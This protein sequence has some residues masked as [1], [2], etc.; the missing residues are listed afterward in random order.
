MVKSIITYLFLVGIPL[1]ALLWILDYGEQRI[2]APPAIAGS[3]S[4]DEPLTGCLDVQPTE[5]TF[6]QSGRFIQVALGEA[7]GEARLDGEELRASVS[8]PNG[9]CS[10][11]EIVGTF[12]VANE[13][14]LGHATGIGCN[15]CQT[16]ALVAQ[17]GGK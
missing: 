14:F 16:V 17:H 9:P 6:K 5:L 3:W 15:A 13:R 2:A 11:V 7:S 8:E 12:D 4:I 1:A 10:S